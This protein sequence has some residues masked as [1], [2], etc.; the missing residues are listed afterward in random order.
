MMGGFAKARERQQSEPEQSGGFD[1][2]LMCRM[3]GCHNRWTVDVLHGRVCSF[4]DDSL[5][6]CGVKP[7]ARVNRLA[8]SPIP[9][10]EAVR[11]FTEP[12]HDG[13]F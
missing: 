12:E 7:T 13:E 2:A 6:R 3:P 10:S 8:S 1:G 5:S 11:P 9:V 4:H